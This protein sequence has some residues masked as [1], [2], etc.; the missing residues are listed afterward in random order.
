MNFFLTM[1]LQSDSEEFASV[2]KLIMTLSHSQ[3]CIYKRFSINMNMKPNSIIA[4][5]TVIDQMQKNDLKLH[6]LFL[7]IKLIRS[8]KAACTQYLEFLEEQKENEIEKEKAI[9]LE[10]IQ[11]ETLEVHLKQDQYKKICKYFD[12]EFAGLMKA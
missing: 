9:Q 7:S 3:A 12:E 5:K 11:F 1:S 6:N 8:V 2:L 10:I 4:R